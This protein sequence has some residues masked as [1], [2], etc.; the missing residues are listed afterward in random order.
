MTTFKLLGYLDWLVTDKFPINSWAPLKPVFS[1]C[2]IY[3]QACLDYFQNYNWKCKMLLRYIIEYC[4]DKA[5]LIRITISFEIHFMDTEN[6][7]KPKTAA[8]N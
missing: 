3:F 2:T 5:E 4:K 8:C 7:M 6:L 1:S